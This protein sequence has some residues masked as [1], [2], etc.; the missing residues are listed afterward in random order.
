MRPI[1]WIWKECAHVC[2]RRRP[3][4]HTS[5]TF[6]F[7]AHA[8]DHLISMSHSNTRV[9]FFFCQFDDMESL[10]AKTIL[11]SLIRQ[12]LDG[13]SL[14][15]IV[16][17]HLAR[18]FRDPFLDFEKLTQLFVTVAEMFAVN[19]IVIDAI[20]ECKK[21][22]RLLLLDVFRKVSLSNKTILKMY[23]ATRDD[24][25]KEI[26]KFSNKICDLPMSSPE[27]SLD[28]A[29]Y[30]ENVIEEKKDNGDLAVRDPKLLEEIRDALIKGAEGM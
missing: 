13:R 21:E 6:I 30:V 27:I 24:I 28:I 2:I 29:T 26:R 4:L 23:M 14:P 10:E 12:G 3:T 11:A 1:S 7:S 5:L 9:A 8:V 16:E 19:F 17:T 15:K 25:G 20:D 22:E 18:I